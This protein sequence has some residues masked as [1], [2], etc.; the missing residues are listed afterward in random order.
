MGRGGPDGPVTHLDAAAA[1]RTPPPVLQAVVSHLHREADVGSYVAQQEAMPVLD[2]LRAD[3]G[4]L[5]GL[6]GGGEA[7]NSAGLAFAPNATAALDALLGAWPLP[8]RDRRPTIGV[9]P[10]EWGPN[11]VRFEHAGWRTLLLPTDPD[12]RLDLDALARHVE[13]L[14]VLHLTQVAAHRGLVQPVAAALRITGPAG[15]PVWV[16]AA[17]A[18]GHVAVPPGVAA[19][20]GTSRK[21]LRGPRGAGFLA[22]AAEH[23]PRLRVRRQPHVDLPAVQHLESTGV[24]PAVLMGL[25][26]AVTALLQA[27][28]DRVYAALDA[29][30]ERT[31]AA[32][33][34]V[35]GWEVLP[36][37]GG[38]AITALRPRGGQ[39]VPETV[40]RLLAEH[41][42]LTTPCLPWRAP[43]E[44]E[45]PRG[46]GPLL[47]VSPHLDVAEQDLDRLADLLSRR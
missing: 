14:D 38:G 9:L 39:D 6:T 26:A 7:G 23:R 22:V 4:V 11:L 31:R 36:D 10:G 37:A 21:W 29:V 45:P 44:M 41:E 30:G 25:A 42:V 18:V 46:T 19:A 8:D 2:R 32:L 17:Q 1:S 13:D 16:D 15:V 35:P 34:D 47:R 33:A 24:A 28:P 20:Y 27:G 40:R 5:C 43:A 3:L 12:G